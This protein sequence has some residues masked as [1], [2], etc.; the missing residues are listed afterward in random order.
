MATNQ[1]EIRADPTSVFNVLA[2]GGNYAGWVVGAKAIPDVDDSFPAV[3]SSF[4]TRVRNGFRGIDGITE[5][6]AVDPPRSLRLRATVGH[7]A[8]AE[9]TF[10]LEPID[11]GTLVTM[12]EEPVGDRPMS[13][14][15]RHTGPLLRVRNAET[16]WRLKSVVEERSGHGRVEA[17]VGAATLPGPLATFT[18]RLFASAAVL[19]GDRGLHPRGQVLSGDALVHTAGSILARADSAPVV[20]RLSRGIG[21]PHPLPDFNGVAIRFLDAHGAGLHQ[22]LLLAA[23]SGRPVLRHVIRPVRS[24]RHSGYSSVLPFRDEGGALRLFRCGPIPLG[25]LGDV[26]SCLPLVLELSVG[27]PLGRWVPAAT[28]TLH[29]LASGAHSNTRY[30]PWNTGTALTPVGLLN[31]LRAPAYAASR[32]ASAVGPPNATEAVSGS[33][34]AENG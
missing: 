1:L 13:V 23:A 32:G 25:A 22:D 15:G 21:L 34:G 20:V 9:I 5:V 12:H 26:A 2:D 7:V 3:G 28:L 24:F 6:L 8:E 10:E 30:D 31:R 19:R 16:L 18:A 11:T 27:T 33:A 14:I 17:S 29:G 4:R